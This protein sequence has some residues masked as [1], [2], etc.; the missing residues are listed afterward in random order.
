MTRELYKVELTNLAISY[1]SKDH[2][3]RESN[4][5]KDYTEGENNF[6]DNN[7]ISGTATLFSAA[8]TVYDHL[9]L[10]VNKLKVY[11]NNLKTF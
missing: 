11:I 2:N 5:R 8:G 7:L 3:I 1:L 4:K 6:E 9:V 10:R